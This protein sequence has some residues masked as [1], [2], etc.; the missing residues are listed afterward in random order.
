MLILL[1]INN[2]QNLSDFVQ[3]DFYIY[4][5]LRINMLHYLAMEVGILKTKSK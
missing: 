3:I 2:P 1:T 5:Q 4:E